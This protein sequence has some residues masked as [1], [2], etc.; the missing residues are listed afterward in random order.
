MSASPFFSMV[1]RVVPS[2]TLFMMT[3]LTLGARR[4]YEGFASSTTST[5]GLWLTNL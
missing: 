2:G 5:P 1:T 3:R 4:Q